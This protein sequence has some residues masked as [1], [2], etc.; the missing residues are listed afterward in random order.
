MQKRGLPQEGL[1]LIACVTMLLDHAA[2]VIVLDCF[3][4]ATGTDKA[5]LLNLYDNLRTVGRIAFPIYCFLLVEGAAHTR[6]PKYYALRLLLSAL[7][8]EIPFDLAIF[9]ALTW[10]H[11]S[12]M[13]TLLLGFLMLEAMKKCPHWLLQLLTVI[14]FGLLAEWMKTDYGAMGIYVVALFALTRE[15]PRRE[16][17]QF[18]GLW[19]IFSP[20]HMMV[21]NW[22][23]GFNLTVQELG[24]FAA[25]PIALYDGRKM[26]RNKAVQW[27]FY[28][29]YPAHLLTLYLIV[30]L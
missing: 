3:Y 13:V 11:Q 6:N 2:I 15:L 18:F 1:K 7:L 21:L 9:G 29:F 22:L 20:N 27:A 8:S 19:F 4:K 28:L 26:T 12:V 17:W 16:I 5:A 23:G 30:R 14:P 24:A 25:L 10:H